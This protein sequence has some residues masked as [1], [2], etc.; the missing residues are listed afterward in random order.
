MDK[1]KIKK[2]LEIEQAFYRIVFLVLIF[3]I[4]AILLFAYIECG[5]LLLVFGLFSAFF[6]SFLFII[7]AP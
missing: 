2:E 1:Q 3:F 7:S 4:I 6:L 5:A